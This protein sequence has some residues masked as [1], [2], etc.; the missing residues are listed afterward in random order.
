[1]KDTSSEKPSPWIHPHKRWRFI[2][3]NEG[4]DGVINKRHS[5]FTPSSTVLRKIK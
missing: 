5:L 2:P 3:V 4:L 1:M